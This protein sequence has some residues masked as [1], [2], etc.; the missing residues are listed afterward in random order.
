MDASTSLGFS[1]RTITAGLELESLGQLGRI[2]E[3]ARFLA[4]ARRL[5]EEEGIP[6][7]STRIA[8]QPIGEIIQALG[9]E[10]AL[11]ALEALDQAV[12]D[13]GLL[14]S[15]GPLL[16]GEMADPGFPSWA[17]E[18]MAATREI[19]FSVAVADNGSAP[20]QDAVLTAA[21]TIR[22]IS[23][24][25]G[26]GEANFR[27]GA[28]ARVPGGTPFFPVAYHSGPAAFS[29]G[30]ESAGLVSAA[31]GDVPSIGEAAAALQAAL[32]SRLEGIQILA[33]Q[34]AADTSVHFTGIDL[35]PAPS[36]DASIAAPIERLTGQPFGA[37]TT[38]SACAAITQALKS[39]RLNSCGYSGLMLPLLEDRVLAQRA[40]EGRFG[41][42]DLLFFSSVCGTGLDVIALPG[43][44][45][46]KQLAR[47]ILDTAVL[48]ARLDKPLAARLL[49]IPGKMAGESVDFS[50]PHLT[51]S[52]VLPTE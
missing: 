49:P 11:Q 37:P 41:V 39:C 9:H 17:A 10:A 32:E 47:L 42:Q 30:L 38:L 2:E 40:A 26:D 22:A 48:S 19:Y 51:A 23:Q 35:S 14:I 50:N 1:I 44:S 6:V 7:Q 8:T 34:I 36:L 28:A 12:V 43:D 29:I 13:L 27:F 5:F 4:A 18:L 16:T 45:T 33:D 31:L 52:V 15:V 3:A 21:R 20:S 46:D 24:V 25:G